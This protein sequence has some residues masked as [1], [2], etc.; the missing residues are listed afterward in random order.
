MMFKII[1]YGNPI[2]KKTSENIENIDDDIL[3]ILDKMAEGMRKSNGIGLAGPQIGL[4][5]NIA[6]VEVNGVLKKII[7]PIIIETSE[8][9]EIME[10]GCL[11]IPLIYEKVKR[12]S[13][14]TVQYMNEKGD[15]VIEKAEGM[16]ARVF[17]H[18]IDHLNGILFV[19]KVSPLAKIIISKKLTRLKKETLKNR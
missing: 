9:E 14:I 15:T 7:N 3:N 4:N 5:K 17:Q 12:H 1:K 10:E 8:E 11:S 6:V 16:W 18:E 13:C 2:L 19:E